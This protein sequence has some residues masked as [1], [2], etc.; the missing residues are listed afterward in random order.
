VECTWLCVWSYSTAGPPGP[1]HILGKWLQGGTYFFLLFVIAAYVLTA[2]VL[3]KGFLV[4][5]EPAIAV[6]SWDSNAT[7]ASRPSAWHPICDCHAHPNTSLCTSFEAHLPPFAP[8]VNVGCISPLS[9]DSVR[10]ERSQSFVA[11]TLQVCSTRQQTTA[12]AIY[13]EELQVNAQCTMMVAMSGHWLAI[14]GN[15]LHERQ[16]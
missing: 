3:N 13:Y 5:S 12:C 2:M 9:S 8:F 15:I 10:E 1:I 4:I 16:S 7:F 14:G 6:A 11:T